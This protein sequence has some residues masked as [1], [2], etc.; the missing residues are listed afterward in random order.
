[1]PVILATA[2]DAP[3]DGFVSWC[4]VGAATPPLDPA[5]RV[6]GLGRAL[7]QALDTIRDEWFALARDMGRE[8]SAVLAH[9]PACAANASD[10]GLMLAWTRVVDGFAAQPQTTLVVCD[11][12]WL[13]RHLASRPGIRAGRP[14][15]L[16]FVEGCLRLRG[17]AARACVA[18]R[19]ALAAGRFSGQRKSVSG[20]RGPWVLAYAH[21]GSA[22]DGTD[23]YFGGL[24]AKV[25]GLARV[26]HVDGPTARAAAICG[27]GEQTVSIHAFGSPLFALSSVGTRWRPRIEGPNAWLI[28]R[29]AAREGGT[30]QAA[31]IAWQIHCQARWLAA[32]RPS[33]VVWPW[34]NHSWE[35]AFVRACRSL[36]VRTAGY[37]HA[38]IGRREWNYAPASNP[39]GAASLPDEI[40]CAGEAWAA[41]LRTFGHRSERPAVGGAW[42]IPAIARLP[43]ESSGSIFVAL[44]S[45][46]A[47]A[48]E[49]I[50]AIRPLA[51][52]G[53]GIS[54]I[55]RDHPMTP[56]PF[57][58]EP[59]IARADG[60]LAGQRSVA[61]V[62]YAGTTLGLEAALGGLPTIR[63]RPETA[64]ANDVLPD[65]FDLPAASA[66]DLGEA[67]R[68]TA[69]PP[70]FDA[71]AVFAPVEIEVWR[72]ALFGAPG[73]A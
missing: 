73:A 27:A 48:A 31:M 34:E 5:R 29:A 45:D 38:T 66:A 35:R 12:P 32:A 28:R 30:G 11:D 41:R 2:T 64:I 49:M 63:F 13:F 19:A 1:M 68:R 53:Q 62:L 9:A 51:R 67:L 21:P 10:F 23:A 46:A 22:A 58:K 6:V 54:F 36:G 4:A 26:L 65:G 42:R 33:A 55:V 15:A 47:I 24:M 16:V 43:R 72:K 40:L 70:S 8:Q 7:E 60:P 44:P 56:F 50:A 57:A 61:A 17:L 39:D 25:E 59:G 69:P 18:V 37:Q 3:R 20:R 52:Q 14:P 71:G